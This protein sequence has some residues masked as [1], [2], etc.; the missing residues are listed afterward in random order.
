M[1][2]QNQTTL[3]STLAYLIGVGGPFNGINIA[4]FTNNIYP[5]R[6]KVFADYTY[7][8]FGGI[9]ALQ[10][11]IWGTPFLNGNSQAEVLGGLINFL[12]TSAPSSPVTAYGYLFVNAGATDWLLAEAFATP[13]VFSL[14]GQY[15]GIVPRMVYDT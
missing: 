10:S 15:L 5:T 4:L 8:T 13:V 3:L 9:T 7:G 14:A 12:T 6:N 2:V 11:I 1:Y